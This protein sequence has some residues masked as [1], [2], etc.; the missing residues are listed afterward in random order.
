MDTV[1]FVALHSIAC[2]SCKTTELCV[3]DVVPAIVRVLA[4]D[5]S[6]NLRIRAIPT[7][8]R[9]AGRDRRAWEAIERATQD[10]P[11]VIVRRAAAEA[12]HGPFFM[13]PKRYERHQRRHDRVAARTWS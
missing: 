2:E 8:L 4:R 11:D 12:L 3:T 7:L 9:L 5:Q 13:P 1:R 6:P 10:D